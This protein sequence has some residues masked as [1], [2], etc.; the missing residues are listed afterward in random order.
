MGF[1]PYGC[2]SQAY[3]AAQSNCTAMPAEHRCIFIVPLHLELKGHNLAALDQYSK[4][5]WVADSRRWHGTQH[6]MHSAWFG[7][8]EY[9]QCQKKTSCPVCSRAPCHWTLWVAAT[10]RC[11]LP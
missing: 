4:H 2:M 11:W 7:I 5:L 8:V 1:V 10:K 6:S 9:K 3:G